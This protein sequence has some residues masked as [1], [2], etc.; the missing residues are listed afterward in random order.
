MTNIDDGAIQGGNG[1]GNPEDG[2]QFKVLAQYV[3]DLSFENPEA[4]QSLR[5]S[6][7]KPATDV[8]IDVQGRKGQNDEYE[9]ELKLIVNSRRGDEILFLV[10]LV[11]AGLFVLKNIPEESLQPALLIECPRLLFPYARELISSLA[12]R[13]GFPQFI[14]APVNFEK[15]YQD[16]ISSQLSEQ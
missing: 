8:S 12:T 5:R 1:A 11:Y 13:G 16:H 7:E 4:P 10:E 3:K 15:L 9:L 6:D 2:P 14:L